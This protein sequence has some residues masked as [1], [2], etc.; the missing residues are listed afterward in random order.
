MDLWQQVDWNYRLERPSV[1]AFA[2]TFRVKLGKANLLEGIAP[3]LSRSRYWISFEQNSSVY[4]AM[5]ELVEHLVETYG[6]EVV[7]MNGS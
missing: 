3:A 4:L 2:R 6:L 1:S 5:K 7:M